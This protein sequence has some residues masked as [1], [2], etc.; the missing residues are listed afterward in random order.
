MDWKLLEERG[1]H[2]YKP[3]HFDSQYVVAKYQKR[4]DDENGKKYFLDVLEYDHSDLRQYNISDEKYGHE[5]ELYLTFGGE[6]DRPMRVLMYCGWTIEQAEEMTEMMW[7]NLGANYYE[8][9]S[10]EEV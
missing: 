1:Y 6:E 5:F 7:K 9:W 8:R 3:S 4:F 10:R 2:K